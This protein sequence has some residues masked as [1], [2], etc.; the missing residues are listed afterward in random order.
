M[1]ARQLGSADSV[2]A[3]SGGSA[4]RC[5]RWRRRRPEARWRRRSRPRPTPTRPPG[6]RKLWTCRT[7]TAT[8]RAACPV[9]R[10]AHS[11]VVTLCGWLPGGGVRRPLIGAMSHMSAPHFVH[12]CFTAC[13]P[14][15]RWLLGGW[16]VCPGTADAEQLCNALANGARLG[17]P[18][19]T[20]RH[21]ALATLAQLLREGGRG[22]RRQPS[23]AAELYHLRHII[24]RAG[25]LNWL[26]FTYEFEIGSAQ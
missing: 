2:A 22:L 24:V 4:R 13:L 11:I 12:A 3:A 18:A 9:P 16:R 21:E 1:Q 7:K 23:R 26:R 19:W 5:W 15:T 25:I 17:Q 10:S 8:V 20:L 6:W 14:L